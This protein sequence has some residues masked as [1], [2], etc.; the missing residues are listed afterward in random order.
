MPEEIAVRK[1]V[2]RAEDEPMDPIKAAYA[3]V[4]RPSPPF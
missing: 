2:A 3:L 4:N 1:I